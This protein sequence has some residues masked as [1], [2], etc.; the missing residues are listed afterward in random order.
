MTE[1]CRITPHVKNSR[2]EEVESNLY[3]ELKGLLSQVG[4]GGRN[5]VL[6]LY[7]RT[8]DS[9]FNE[10]MKAKGATFDENG[11]VTLYD[12]INLTE[13][14][15]QVSENNIIDY[16]NSE[17]KGKTFS[18]EQA[19]EE[20]NKINNSIWNR[21][22]VATPV[23]IGKNKFQIEV[24]VQKPD[25]PN[26]HKR[27]IFAGRLSK[28]LTKLLTDW[29]VG[30]D[31]YDELEDNLTH[32]YIDFE[33]IVKLPDGLVHLI[34]IAKGSIGRQALPEEFAHFVIRSM[35]NSPLITRALNQLKQNN[36][37]VTVLGEAYEQYKQEYTRQAEERGIS[38]EELLVEEA[39]GKLLAQKIE[40]QWVND[41]LIT[42][43]WNLFKNIFSKFDENQ[44]RQITL[45]CDED[46][47][48]L[49]ED[50][51]NGKY[52]NLQ[53]TNL[54]RGKLYQKAATQTR[55]IRSIWDKFYE[56]MLRTN[57]IYN[58]RRKELGLTSEEDEG[59][60]LESQYEVIEKLDV[61]AH[62]DWSTPVI[63]YENGK[64]VYKT[65]EEFTIDAA[66]SLIELAV[67]NTKKI[68][69]TVAQLQEQI[70]NGTY[71]G[72]LNTACAKVRAIMDY[73]EAYSEIYDD[74]DRLL[75]TTF[76]DPVLDSFP[77]IQ[78]IRA[79]LK[80][81][82]NLLRDQLEEIRGKVLGQKNQRGTI[83]TNVKDRLDTYKRP[84]AIEV[85]LQGFKQFFPEDV[86]LAF[87][88]S[89]NGEVLTLEEML[90]YA[91]YDITF[92]SAWANSMAN[93]SDPI[94]R[95]YDAVVKKQKEEA[96]QECLN[97]QR[98][99]I[100]AG[101]KLEKFG[102]GARDHSWM[103]ERYTKDIYRNDP[104]GTRVLIHKKGDLVLDSTGMPMYI[105]AYD[106]EAARIDREKFL[107]QLKNDRTLTAEQKQQKYTEFLDEKYVQR[108]GQMYPKPE[109][110]PSESY[111]ALTD[112]QKEFYNTFMDCKRKLDKYLPLYTGDSHKAIVVRKDGIQRILSLFKG[113]K[114][115]TDIHVREAFGS[116]WDWLKG[117]VKRQ[118]TDEDYGD[119]TNTLINFSGKE[120]KKIPIYYTYKAKETPLFNYSTN[121]VANMCI[122]AQTA[123]N[124]K[125]MAKVIE[126]LELG[127]D[128]M[129]F[130]YTAKRFADTKLIA[131]IRD[132]ARTFEE[133]LFLDGT[134]TNFS[135]RLSNYLDMQ[136]YGQKREK[137]SK[138]A[139]IFS[140][141]VGGFTTAASALVGITNLLQ[142]LGQVN[143]EMLAGEYFT[144]GDLIKAK[145][146][147]WKNILPLLSRLGSKGSRSAV[148]DS[149]FMN[150][151]NWL[152]LMS[153]DFNMMQD[154]DTNIRD[155]RQYEKNP[156]A[157][158]NVNSALYI[159]NHLGE[160]Y[161]QH[162]TF[163]AM[164]NH[165]KIIDS[166]GKYVSVLD[167]YERVPLK[168]GSSSMKLALKHYQTAIGTSQSYK[169]EDGR[170]I[171][172]MEQL[173]ARQKYRKDKY[174]KDVDLYSKSLLKKNEIAEYEWK[175]MLTRKGAKMN[176]DMHGIYNED[177]KNQLQQKAWGSLLIMYRKHI[178]PNFMKRW[179]Q[180][181]YD[182][183][184]GTMTT[185]YQREL[186]KV[187]FSFFHKA[188]DPVTGDRRWAFNVVKDNWTK[189]DT[190]NM[191]RNAAQALNWLEINLLISILEAGLDDN[192]D[193]WYKLL[194]ISAYR[195]KTE[196]SQFE[197]LA[198]VAKHN[199][200]EEWVRLIEQPIVGTNII[201]N[202]VELFRLT[203]PEVWKKEMQNGPYAGKKEAEKII[204]N[205]I[206]LARQ[207]RQHND[208]S[209]LLKFYRRD[210]GSS[211]LTDYFVSAGKEASNVWN[212]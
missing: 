87:G 211:G 119:T 180:E 97:I 209:E 9:K 12:M 140:R 25:N 57:V 32:G 136:V 51:L 195:A 96:R 65:K 49:A 74:F 112:A 78:E 143:I 81:S 121:L 21:A 150:S 139:E 11:E 190:R 205:V 46:L 27:V 77:Q 101:Q 131:Q 45:E 203:D 208:P 85:F 6:P 7:Q 18:K 181:G 36:L 16:L 161:M 4:K 33:D 13:I 162:I 58:K 109:Y 179:K 95:M 154:W 166:N 134:Q 24:E 90:T 26:K 175:G 207:I 158:V 105:K 29:G 137:R 102:F 115:E 183:D 167:A 165:E 84:L 22:Y 176:Q 198:I 125:A 38:V 118:E 1:S 200:L 199:I 94:A 163:L 191:L 89:L 187:F 135:K 178:A 98:I 189:K 69:T 123:T 19:F 117:L 86:V 103:Y 196:N 39:L 188:I 151:A 5:Q 124:Y 159:L 160:H 172:T 8:L 75:D 37:Y 44:I 93:T 157:R 197:P 144:T 59:D 54:G 10:D 182:A 76:A 173:K 56:T 62:Q 114:N 40:N 71:K 53:T 132:G 146:L 67:K 68:I 201:K 2:G 15:S 104:D 210:V 43:I 148:L 63:R 34:K 152:N 142:G 153:Q 138:V 92:I 60:L 206:P 28:R 169:T 42:R 91:D 204:G 35:K 116:L 170:T 55:Q 3:N 72:S 177:D 111:L 164:L 155:L 194:L 127:H 128:I 193:L 100:E 48:F 80:D 156:L 129:N 145:A 61:A 186:F 88:H 31:I 106:E 130:R 52:Q 70:D 171:V 41:N 113:D 47:N 20:S 212:E 126:T 107:K 120:V 147:Y 64:P 83:N 14:G 50:L 202:F 168:T 79:Q 108:K 184:L 17:F 110:Y 66:I 185:G 122:Y 82:K 192:D 174:N 99:I 30:V 73:I 133:Q 23:K 149:A 141:F